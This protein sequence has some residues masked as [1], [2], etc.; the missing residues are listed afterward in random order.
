ML[1]ALPL[2]VACASTPGPAGEVNRNTPSLTPLS[3][4]LARR[5]LATLVLLSGSGAIPLAAQCIVDNPGGSKA[6]INRPADTDVPLAG[7]SP[8]SY[9]DQAMPDWLCF[10]LGYRARMEGYSAG[11][12][13]T[14]NSDSYLLTRFRFG[15][16]L[17]PAS[18]LRVFA[19]LQDATAFWKD[20][21]L[22]P[23][24]QSTWDLRRAYVDLGDIEEG[25]VAFRVG[26]QDLNFG[27]GRLL[28]TAYWRNASRGYDAAMGVFNWDSLRVNVFAASQVVVAPSGLCHHQEGNDVHGI[29]GTL[30]KLVPH[31][32]V[33]P[34]LF[35][36]LAPGIKTEEGNLAKLDEK[37]FGVRWAGTASRFDFD[38]ETVGQTGNIGPDNIRAW[39][40]E[41]HR[42]LQPATAPSDRPRLRQIRLRF[43]RRTIQRTACTGPS[44]NSTRTFTTITASP[45][46]SRGRTSSP[47]VRV[48][49]V[50]LRRNWMLASAYNGWWL[51]SA[52]DAFYN[53][54]GS[55]VARDTKGLSGTHIGNE[56]DV[57]TSYRVDRNLELGVGV[58]YIRS[59]EFLI[60]TGHARSYTYPYVM[61]NYNFF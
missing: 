23:P 41:R 49:R 60:R 43:R 33:E 20:A 54:S 17:K 19:E 27:Y 9:L 6:N 30:R 53:S 18:W 37:S 31:S 10:T 11:N 28:G 21:P 35:W 29:Y 8:L 58:G 16:L 34:Y 24:Y 12:F 15:M 45:T 56:Y 44:I 25:H 32:T 52:T 39:A 7:F 42:R 1:N 46:R 5:L 40:C 48:S 57:Q 2:G 3:P 26:R 59:G 4:K 14:G 22:A 13:Q 36:H 55:I 51:A 61:M 50:A 47:S 38:A